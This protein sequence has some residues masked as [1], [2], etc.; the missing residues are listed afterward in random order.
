LAECLDLA[1]IRV[2]DEPPGTHVNA[3]HP[4]TPIEPD[5]SIKQCDGL[6]ERYSQ[7]RAIC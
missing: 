6:A 5:K 1:K 2:G 3:H 7:R 4:L